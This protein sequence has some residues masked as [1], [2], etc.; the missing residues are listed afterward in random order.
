MS[1]VLNHSVKCRSWRL[2]YRN[3]RQKI[4]MKKIVLTGPESA[5]KTTL[6]GQLARHFGTLWVPEFARGYLATLGRPYREGDLLEIAKGQMALEDEIAQMAS[7]IVFLDTSL[8]VVQVWSEVVYGKCH[9]LITKQSVA[10]RPDLYILC[11]PD[12]PWEPD[13]LRENPHNRGAL[14]EIYLEKLASLGASYEVVDGLGPARLD[15]AI[16]ITQSF[17]NDSI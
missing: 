2:V 9:P 1:W 17:L 16:S 4:F 6:A 13:P 11:R 3:G 15:K 5:G 14:F 8:E 12:L 10:R 7:G